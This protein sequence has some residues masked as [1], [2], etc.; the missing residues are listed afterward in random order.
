MAAVGGY[1]RGEMAPFSDV[2]LLFLY[3]YK[4]TPWVEQVIEFTLYL[5]WDL[6][7]KLGHSAR[8]ID[9]CMRQAKA[10]TTISTAMLKRASSSAMTSCTARC[11]GV[12]AATSSLARPPNS[13]MRNWSNP[14]NAMRVWARIPVMVEPNVKDGK[15]GLRDLHTLQ[16]I[17]KFAY[18]VEDMAAL[19]ARGV[20]DPS[21]ARRF[22][23]AQRHLWATRCHLHYLVGRAEER[24]TLM[25]SRDR[26]PHGLH[27]SRWHGGG[28]TLY[29]A[30]LPNRQR[31]RRSDTHPLRGG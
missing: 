3:P 20:L 13:S 14:T 27:R 28:R 17:A 21:E 24:L 15:G 8:S 29:E 5:L 23:K 1:G 30:L 18:Q 9:E 25:C 19:V 7:L 2:D 12:M 22:A 16:W 11:A 6:G 10:D 4:Q 31:C 26:R